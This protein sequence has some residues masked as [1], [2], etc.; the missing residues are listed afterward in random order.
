MYI[1]T[2]TLTHTHTH[3]HTHMHTHVLLAQAL[4]SRSNDTLLASKP[5][6]IIGVL[7]DLLLTLLCAGLL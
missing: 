6:V 4:S 7:F 3:T 5:T 2:H 1:Y